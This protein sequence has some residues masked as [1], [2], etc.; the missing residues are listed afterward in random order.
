MVLAYHGINPDSDYAYS[1]S[2]EQFAEHI[3]A[4]A[5]TKFSSQPVA[6]TF[7]DGVQSQ[8]QNGFATL[9]RYSMK[10]TFFVL[11]GLIGKSQKFLRWEQLREMNAAGQ[12]IQSHGW[13]H[14]FLTQCSDSELDQELLASRRLLEERLG[15]AV[16]EISIPFGRWN[17]RVLR[18]CAAA[19]YRKVFHSDPW[20]QESGENLE[21]TGRFMVRRS[22]TLSQMDRLRRGERGSFW[23]MRIHS[24]VKSQLRR[25]IGDQNY[26]RLWQ[27]FSNFEMDQDQVCW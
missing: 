6:I 1:V 2:C 4:F 5:T 27:R 21:L 17:G 26:H 16:T 23:K 24:T 13:S 12:S 9:E 18:A 15:T 10:A 14:R 25:T 11:A 20:M 8:Y 22:T 7:D 3:R 19:G